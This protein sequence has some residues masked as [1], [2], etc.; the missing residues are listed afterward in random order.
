MSEVELADKVLALLRSSELDRKDEAISN[1]VALA[2]VDAPA[3]IAG[4]TPR[5]EAFFAIA[6]LEKA[7]RNREDASS[8]R[9]RYDFA[10]LL[11][12]KWLQAAR[13]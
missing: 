11:A 2:R 5:F 3:T 7:L 6:T 4:M 1:A 12:S 8:I 13:S 10:L 9:M